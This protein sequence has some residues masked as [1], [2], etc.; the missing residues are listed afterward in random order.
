MSPGVV[1]QRLMQQYLALLEETAM[2]G[3]AFPSWDLG[4]ASCLQAA[5]GVVNRTTSPRELEAILEQ[6]CPDVEDPEFLSYTILEGRVIGFAYGVTSA[7]AAARLQEKGDA[8]ASSDAAGEEWVCRS[9]TGTPLRRVTPAPEAVARGP[10][11]LPETMPSLDGL[12]A[13]AELW[14]GSSKL[15]YLRESSAD[16]KFTSADDGDEAHPN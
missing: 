10:D 14:H 15:P 3:G 16:D 7:H 11:G 1:A 4:C 8:K 5:H 9:K 12:R 13:R 6:E 2:S